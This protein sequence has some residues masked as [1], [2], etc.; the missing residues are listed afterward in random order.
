ML[1]FTFKLPLVKWTKHLQQVYLLACGGVV[2]QNTEHRVYG[3]KFKITWILKGF[4]IAPF[5]ANV[6]DK[7]IAAMDSRWAKR[8]SCCCAVVLVAFTQKA[9]SSSKFGWPEPH[10]FSIGYS[11]ED[12]RH[13]T[14]N[15]DDLKVA[16][17]ATWASLTPQQDHIS[18][19][20]AAI[21][22]KGAPTKNWVHVLFFKPTFLH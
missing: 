9:L 16:I 15:A 21:H 2:P 3:V 7:T 19:I 6:P 22:A 20:D 11:Q 1:R 14:D 12:E 4:R 8:Q 10:R 13:Q 17:K 18:S 5:L